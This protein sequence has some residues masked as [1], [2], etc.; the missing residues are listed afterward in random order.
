MTADLRRAV[1]RRW[2][3]YWRLS[4]ADRGIVWRSVLLLG[5]AALLLKFLRLQ[6][7][8][9]WLTRLLPATPSTPAVDRLQQAEHITDLFVAVANLSPLPT[10]CLPRAVALWWL[11]R[12]AGIDAAIVLGVRPLAG[13]V[14]AHAWVDCAGRVLGDAHHLHQAYST[15]L[16]RVPI[17][18]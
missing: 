17:R 14:T 3:G 8:V 2:Q 7:A 11:L 12:R 5:M 15:I 18:Q 1:Q 13:A 10:T 16:T 4:P 6:R 9:E